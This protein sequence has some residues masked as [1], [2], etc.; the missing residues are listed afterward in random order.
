MEE[1]TTYSQSRIAKNTIILCIRML[2]TMGITLLSSRILL[3][4]LGVEDY[5]VYNIIGGIVVLLSVVS[6]SMMSATQRFITYEI[7]KGSVESVTSV[8]SM[9]LI[10]HMIIIGI[11]FVLGETIGLWYV[12]KNA[13]AKEA[14]D[15]ELESEKSQSETKSLESNSSDESTKVE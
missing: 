11:I 13:L 14:A 2:I 9:S 5:G 3:S 10:A 4:T 12:I 1:K 6:N 7:G 8:F 15:A